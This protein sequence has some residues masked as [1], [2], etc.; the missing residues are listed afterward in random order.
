MTAS[1]SCRDRAAHFAVPERL[2]GLPVDVSYGTVSDPAKRAS[3]D[4]DVVVHG[5]V[6][7]DNGVLLALGECEWGQIMGT[8][9]LRWTGCTAGSEPVRR[10]PGLFL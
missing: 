1:S 5:A 3:Y 8:G 9:D 10:W 4:A 7:Q 6:G 2:G